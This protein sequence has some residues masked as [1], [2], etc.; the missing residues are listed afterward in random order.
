MRI[1]ALLGQRPLLRQQ[2]YGVCLQGDASRTV[3]RALSS[4]LLDG[5]IAR[6]M[7]QSWQAAAAPESIVLSVDQATRWLFL[8]MICWGAQ[9]PG[10]LRRHMRSHMRTYP[11]PAPSLLEDIARR[12]RDRETYFNVTLTDRPWQEPEHAETV[13]TLFQQTKWDAV[14]RAANAFVDRQVEMLSLPPDQRR[15]ALEAMVEPSRAIFDPDG[16]PPVLAE[17]FT[18]ESRQEATNWTTSLLLSWLEPREMALAMDYIDQARAQHELVGI[19]LALAVYR[20]ES[21]VYPDSLDALSPDIIDEVGIDSFSGQPY[22]YERTDDGYVLYSVGMNL[23]NDGGGSRDD[24]PEGSDA[25]DIVI[26]VGQP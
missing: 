3:A 25:D 20:A 24:R 13:V 6:S 4:G 14:L 1:G 10:D 17:P 11:A 7:A 15:T 12:H 19:A 9:H 8:D 21:G 26:R 16:Q 18:E 23:T 2:M 22:V 5:D